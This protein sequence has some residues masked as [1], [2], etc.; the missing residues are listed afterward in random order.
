MSAYHVAKLVGE[1]Q[2]TRWYSYKNAEVKLCLENKTLMLSADR[3][4]NTTVFI[5]AS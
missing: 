2:L 3:H 5:V 4:T 1:A